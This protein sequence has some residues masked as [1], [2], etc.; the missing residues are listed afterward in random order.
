MRANPKNDWRIDDVE[1]VCRTYGVTVDPPRG[2]SH[3]VLWHSS[4]RERLSIPARRPIKPVYI[5]QLV[6]L[7]RRRAA[8]RS[9]TVGLPY[10]IVV[11]P[12]S[13]D[14]GG[15]YLATVP[16]LPGC[17]SDGETPQDAITN[18]EDAAAAWIASARLHGW[19]VPEPFFH[20]A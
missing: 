11:E 6:E 14:D 1:A 15:G 10:R 4:Q 13:P 18:V 8:Q 19:T 5:R 2:S 17:M 3:Y 9:M 7:H 12:L 20:A 16:D